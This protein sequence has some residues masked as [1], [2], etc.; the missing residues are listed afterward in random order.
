VI[1]SDS[2]HSAITSRIFP[3]SPPPSVRS[4]SPPFYSPI[5]SPEPPRPISPA[6]STSSVEF[7]DEIRILSPRPRHYYYYDPHQSLDNLILQFLQRTTPLP[8]DSYSIGPDDFDLSEIKSAI[9]GQNRPKLLFPSSSLF[10]PSLMKYQFVSF[11]TFSHL[12][13]PLSVK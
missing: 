2:P 12:Q 11:S 8:P 1:E 4:F 13:Q 9:S 6:N 3:D 5:S 7:I 10:L